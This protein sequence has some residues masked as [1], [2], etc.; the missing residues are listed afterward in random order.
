MLT[1]ASPPQLKPNPSWVLDT[2]AN[3]RSGEICRIYHRTG[4]RTK[5]RFTTLTNQILAGYVT[6]TAAPGKER[7]EAIR[8]RDSWD[9]G[10]LLDFVIF[11]VTFLLLLVGAVLYLFPASRQAS[12]IPGLTPAEEK[13]GN[14]Q[15][16]V[17]SGS[18]HEFLVNLHDRFGPIASFW[19]GRRLVVSLGSVELLKQHINPNWTSDPFETMLKSLLGYQSG[20]TGDAGESLLRKKLYEAGVKKALQS[21][22]DVMLKLSE[23]L[24]SKWL[25]YPESQH[26]PLCQHMLGFAMKSVTQTAMGSGFEDDQEVLRFRKNHDAI[27]S[28]IG[29]GFLDGSLEKSMTRK[30]LFENFK[31]VLTLMQME[32]VLKKITNERRGRNYSR[33]VFMD[34]LLLQ[35]SL[36]DKQVQVLQEL[37][38][39]VIWEESDLEGVDSLLDLLAKEYPFHK[40]VRNLV[41]WEWDTPE[42]GLRVGR[43]K[44]KLYPLLEET[45][46][47]VGS[48]QSGCFGVSSHEEDSYS[49][50]GLGCLR[51]VQDRKLEL[52]LKRIFEVLTLAIRAA[53]CSSLMQRACLR[54]VQ[55]LQDSQALEGLCGQLVQ[56]LSDNETTV[57]YI[58]QQVCTWAVYFLTT[59]EQVQ[60]KLFKEMNQVLAKGPV[61]LEKM[62]QLRY[63]RQVLCE[64]VP[65]A[66]LTPIAAWLQ[67]LE[68]RVNQHVIPK[69]TLVLYAVGVVLQDSTAWPSAYRF[70]PGRFNDE[71]ACK[72]LSFLGFSGNQE[73]PELR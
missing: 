64:M 33:H 48:S 39:K 23:E 9:P 7:R 5:F 61:T 31:F 21:N 36:S 17:N 53:V 2:R 72:S 57:A 8:G 3:A 22:F 10:T 46:E 15:D 51:D 32:S 43:A 67:E 58:N 16:I 25:S 11:A 52:H 44:A 50:C 6:T 73:C 56:V 42:S 18:L 26:V 71:L 19:F 30:K 66:K 55:Q 37:G 28:E 34:S 54:W 70:D 38:F 63:C 27:W 65:T 14:L 69:E 4:P 49:N 40:S 62:E 24:L 41:V 68:G 1:P 12:S 59:S 20:A 29:K 45:L 13:D 47:Y 60:E 35:G